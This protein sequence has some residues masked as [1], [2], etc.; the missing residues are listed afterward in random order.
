MS[1]F[2]LKIIFFTYMKIRDLFVCGVFLSLLGTCACHSHRRSGSDDDN[3]LLGNPSNATSD[4]INSENYLINHKYYVESYSKSKGEPNWVSWHIS[5]NDLG[6][7]DRMNDF[8]P[9]SLGLPKG[10]FEAEKYSYRQ[11]GFDRG[12]LCPSSDRTNSTIANSATFL[13]DNIIPQAPK[14]NRYT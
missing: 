4:T 10:S 12:H 11:S 1:A 7:V 2:F 3:L 5:S 8:R 13:M 6:N 14:N 9:D